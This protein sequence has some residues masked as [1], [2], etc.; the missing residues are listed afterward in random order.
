MHG[1][2]HV[3][4]KFVLGHGSFHQG[5][6]SLATLLSTGAFF[7]KMIRAAAVVLRPPFVQI[8]YGQ[9][10]S[11]QATARAKILSDNFMPPRDSTKRVGKKTERTLRL[12]EA[13][14]QKCQEWCSMFNG[15][16]LGA[17]IIH[18]CKFDGSTCNCTSAADSLAKMRGLVTAHMF[19]T[20]MVRPEIQEWTKLGSAINWFSFAELHN[21][22]LT[23]LLS[24]AF[25]GLSPEAVAAM[26]DQTANVDDGS[27][28]SDA[29][30]PFLWQ[31]TVG[32]RVGTVN[33][34]L[35]CV[36]ASFR[37]LVLAFVTKAAE[38][39]VFKLEN[40]Q[41]KESGTRDDS[42]KE[43][44]TCA[45]MDVCCRKFS[46]FTGPLQF[47]SAL[48]HSEGHAVA[49]FWWATLG[50]TSCAGA[51]VSCLQEVNRARRTVVAASA[52]LFLRGPRKFECL[53][54]TLASIAD[55]RLP[56]HYRFRLAADFVSLVKLD[57]LSKFALQLH[58]ACG[59]NPHVLFEARWQAFLLKW[60]ELHQFHTQDIERLHAALRRLIDQD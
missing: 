43:S 56:K 34:E 57:G 12:A 58:A 17:N 44:G 23:K 24:V 5:L 25:Q 38:S 41:S 39:I 51:A 30:A 15:D 28:I 32:A 40:Y 53:H 27:R 60:A 14:K 54:W 52:W 1:V 29:L 18:Y 50:C 10:P 49:E 48:L 19:R 35:R 8:V 21:H 16:P 31:K 26:R 2:Q 13:Y 59:G 22:L 55:T 47:L 33:R 3:V 46:F 4:A 9:A 7:L 11:P 36:H 37:A 20:R 45:L 42:S 6:L